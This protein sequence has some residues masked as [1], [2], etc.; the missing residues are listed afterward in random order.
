MA[1]TIALSTGANLFPNGNF[2]LNATGTSPVYNLSSQDNVDL[3]FELDITSP[4]SLSWQ[5]EYS[6]NSTFT[7]PLIV[8]NTIPTTVVAGKYFVVVK[9][10]Y[11]YVRLNRTAG[12][13]NITGN[14]KV[15]V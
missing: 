5:V 2:T 1:T 10:V 14:L 13:G 8:Q 9:R 7:T 6:V 11:D 15:V 4:S 3:I 12:T